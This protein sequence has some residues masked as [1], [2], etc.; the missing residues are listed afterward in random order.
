[1]GKCWDKYPLKYSLNIPRH[2]LW[3]CVKGG[4]DESWVR[5]GSDPTWGR[6]GCRAVKCDENT[7][8]RGKSAFRPR[9]QGSL[10]HSRNWYYRVVG[11]CT[12]SEGEGVVRWWH[13]R[14]RRSRRASQ[15][16]FGHTGTV[17]GGWRS[18]GLGYPTRKLPV[19]PDVDRSPM[20]GT[21][22]GAMHLAQ[23]IHDP[24]LP[25]I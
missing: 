5:K 3:K 18:T 16:L 13:R 22:L 14:G 25:M 9:G 6:S 15:A 23:L 20:S 21:V 2:I 19:V 1:M 17:H 10:A 12:V 24:C 7:S 8:Q 4:Q 11:A